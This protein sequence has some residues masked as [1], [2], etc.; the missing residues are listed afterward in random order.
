M[1]V[2]MVTSLLSGIFSKFM[3]TITRLLVHSK[4]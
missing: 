3:D 4:D 1:V 2:L